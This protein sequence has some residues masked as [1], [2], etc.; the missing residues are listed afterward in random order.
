MTAFEIPD[1]IDNNEYARIIGK[2][3]GELTAK[4]ASPVEPKEPTPT[5]YS[6]GKPFPGT[7]EDVRMSEKMKQGS[8]YRPQAVMDMQQEFHR[9][10]A[11]ATQYTRA[12]LQE[13][14]PAEI[15]AAHANGQLDGLLGLI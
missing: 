2:I 12:D 8:S 9:E 6:N 11:A 1:N 5:L 3:A 4:Q 14:S 7:I 10:V 13:M 15:N